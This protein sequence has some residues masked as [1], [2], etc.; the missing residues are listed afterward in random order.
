MPTYMIQHAT[1]MNGVHIP[2]ER[3]VEDEKDLL[4]SRKFNHHQ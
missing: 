2:I 3:K 4:G 1:T